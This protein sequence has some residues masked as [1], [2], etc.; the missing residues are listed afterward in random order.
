M[1]SG[2]FFYP[3]G[4]DNDKDLIR[5]MIEEKEDDMNFSLLKISSEYNIP[6]IIWHLDAPYN[7]FNPAYCR[8]Y[9]QVYHFCIDKSRT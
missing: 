8:N 7:Y 2:F 5:R 3:Y 6:L 9:R 1:P 4:P